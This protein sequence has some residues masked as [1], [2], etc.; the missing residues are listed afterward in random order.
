MITLL[1]AAAGT[2]K[3]TAWGQFVDIISKPDNMPVAGAL[4]L[5]VVFTWVSLRQAFHNDRLIAENRKSEIIT[6]MQK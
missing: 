6:D 2:H 4:L 1:S 3:L 5:V